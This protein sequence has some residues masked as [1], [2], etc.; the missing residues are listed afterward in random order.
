MR[1]KSEIMKKIYPLIIVLIAH[2]ANA[3]SKDISKI[4]LK[5]SAQTLIDSKDG[6]LLM[7]AYGE[8]HFNQPFAE[9]IQYN[10]SLDVHRQVLLFGYKF[11]SKTSFITEI[12]IEH[13][14]EVYLEQAFLN[15]KAKPWLNL[16]A[17]LML[18][19]MGIVNEYHEPTT[20][21]GVERPMINNV[22]IPTT[23][24]EIGAGIAG[25]LS[26]IGLRYQ[27]YAVNGPLGYDNGPKLSGR[28]PIRGARQKG[29]QVTISD[30]DL[31]GRLTY[32]GIK[33]LNFGFSGYFGQTESSLF[34]N[35]NQDSTMLSRQADSSSIGINMI[36]SD[37]RYQLK[38]FEARGEFIWMNLKNTNEYNAITDQDLGQTAYGYYAE[39]GY[40]IGS[41]FNL[42]NKL[43]PFIRYSNYDTHH[44]V[45]TNQIRNLNYN[46]EVIT[47]GISCFLNPNFVVKADYQKQK[48]GKNIASNTFN[49]GVG[50]WFR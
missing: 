42:K 35:L 13:I 50:Y 29:S 4:Q 2:F 47:T 31:S 39:V 25:N 22:I 43:V 40:N 19:P 11:D 5:N 34:N 18:I 6:N 27:V 36:S 12:E 45:S 9:N 49:A 20:F 26:D 46:N 3:Q 10:G 48:N 24:R 21:N 8:V 23:W 16:Q 1:H 41:I 37:F 38:N 28:K 33:G 30:F 32:Y 7:A 14:K 15:Y 17:G 44:K